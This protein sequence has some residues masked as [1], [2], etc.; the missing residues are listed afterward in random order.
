MADAR[1]PVFPLEV[2]LFPGSQIPLHIFE[3]R[4]RT[5]INESIESSTPFGINFVEEDRLHAVG[6]MAHVVQVIERY[7]DGRLDIVTEGRKRYEVVEFEQN[8]PD[9]L[10][11]ATVRYF[12]DE[13]EERDLTLGRETIGLFNELAEL[14]YEGSIDPLDI[15]V[16]N[17]TER[18][19][20]FMVAQKSGL[21]PA[22]RQALLP[23]VSENG[24]MRI[25]NRVLKQ[26]LPKI[27]EA[28]TIQGLIRNDGY[29]VTWNKLP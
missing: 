10:S 27:K 15:D 18:Q 7:P 14:A 2:V 24:R 21:E 29:L 20:S 8:A 11:F 25:L 16:W 28:E 3:E 4:Y 23:M 26:L 22:Q 6:C 19:P 13:P 9:Q 1:I 17:T 12:E 5:L